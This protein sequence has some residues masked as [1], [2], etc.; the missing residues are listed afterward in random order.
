MYFNYLSIFILFLFFSCKQE[1]TSIDVFTKHKVSYE[2]KKIVSAKNG[3]SLEVPKNWT[4]KDEEYDYKNILDNIKVYSPANKDG[5]ISIL[6]VEKVKSFKGSKSIIDNFNVFLKLVEKN[7]WT[8]IDSGKSSLLKSTS[9]FIHYKT[10]TGTEAESESVVFIMD[11]GEEGVFYYLNAGGSQSES[12][13]KEIALMLDIFSTF[14][15][16]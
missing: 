1:P 16:V 15:K 2:H 6:S 10:D 5:F 13:E 7:K 3:F 9:Y 8:L 11:S 4:T 12:L 14:K